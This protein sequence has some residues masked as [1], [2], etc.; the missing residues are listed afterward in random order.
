MASILIGLGGFGTGVVRRVKRLFEENP[1]YHG[2]I[3]QTVFFSSIDIDP[4]FESEIASIDQIYWEGFRVSRPKHEIDKLF[5]EDANFKYWWIPGFTL[6]SE[7]KGTRGAGQ[8]RIAGRLAFYLHFPRIKSAIKERIDQANEL[9]AKLQKDQGMAAVNTPNVVFLVSSLAGGTGSGILIDTA[10]LVRSLVDESYKIYGVFCDGS[11]V[12]KFAGGNTKLYGFATLTEIERWMEKGDTFEFHYGNINAT[13]KG[14]N[15]LFDIVFL[16]QSDNLQGR[17]F[18]VRGGGDREIRNNYQELLA[19]FLGTLLTSI[20]FDET[21][22]ANSWNRFDALPLTSNGRSRNYSTFG[23]SHISFPVHKVTNY[24][25][26]RLISEVLKLGFDFS[27][28]DLQKF[29]RDN[30]ICERDGNQLTNYLRDKCRSARSYKA[31]RDRELIRFSAPRI[32]NT[33]SF[34]NLLAPHGIEKLI[35]DYS[36]L[37]EGYKKELSQ[38]LEDLKKVITKNFERTI[39]ELVASLRFDELNKILEEFI[40][41]MQANIEHT[42]RSKPLWDKA[43][44]LRE[45]LSARYD[46]VLKCKRGFMGIGDEFPSRKGEFVATLKQWTDAEIQS[47][48]RKIMEKFYKEIIETTKHIKWVIQYLGGILNDYVAQCARQTGAYVQHDWIVDPERFSSGEYLLNLELSTSKSDVDEY[49]Y[50]DIKKIFKDEGVRQEIINGCEKKYDGIGTI[51]RELYDK[52]IQ[53]PN[54]MAK[55]LNNSRNEYAAKLEQTFTGA[56]KSKVYDLVKRIRVDDAM[57]WFLQRTYNEVKNVMTNGSGAEQEGVKNRL[58]MVFGT[59]TAN[60]LMNKDYNE[61]RWM[62]EAAR[63]ILKQMSEL[64][65]PFIKI[66]ENDIIRDNQGEDQVEH[67]KI[68]VVFAPENFKFAKEIPVSSCIYTK[69]TDRITFYTQ[70]SFFPLYRVLSFKEI[71]EAYNKHVETILS[72]VDKGRKTGIPAHADY[73]F[74]TIWRDNILHPVAK[75][76]ERMKDVILLILLGMAMGFIKRDKQIFRIY[77]PRGEEIGNPIRGVEA[78]YNQLLNDQITRRQLGTLVCEKFMNEYYG[79]DKLKAVQN[80]FKIAQ[81]ELKKIKTDKNSSSYK[82]L[83]LLIKL[84]SIMDKSTVIPNSNKELEELA[85][86]LQQLRQ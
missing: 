58:S 79:D 8:I 22:A 55:S 31:K 37:I 42:N 51:I 84:S 13:V 52:Y 34:V 47:A 67:I 39:F 45:Q 60:L 24:C 80:L 19:S 63:G 2:L 32:K 36:D 4:D 3:N 75:E 56:I 33:A 38:E 26:S 71:A 53:D 62:R 44:A 57:T 41:V 7:I 25:Y 76:E 15:R 11:V 28:P 49:I 1:A 14:Q 78:L 9:R 18:Y 86:R 6:E 83:S 70:L 69:M 65:Q 82:I 21:L 12:E 64:T 81:Q 43:D 10:M 16:I 73:R 20:D 72:A 50:P 74:Y 85:K 66:E 40:G 27:N 30:S 46:A 68:Q 35:L 29:E 61:D 48:E 5:K 54:K 17:T 23:I 59:A 77:S